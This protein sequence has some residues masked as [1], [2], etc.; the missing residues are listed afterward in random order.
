MRRLE[1]GKV[2]YQKEVCESAFIHGMVSR[3]TSTH[4]RAEYHSPSLLPG[5]PR[6][7]LFAEEVCRSGSVSR[8]I[9]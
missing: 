3:A 1:V 2:V 5:P 6:Y 9:T 7:D 8:L 4:V